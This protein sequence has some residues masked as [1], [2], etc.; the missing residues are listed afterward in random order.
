MQLDRISIIGFRS[1]AELNDL[2]IASPTLLTGHND[3]GKTTIL[4]AVRFLLNDYNLS[5]R[6]PTFASK[7]VAEADGTETPRVNETVVVGEFTLSTTESDE[8]GLPASIKIRRYTARGRS[9][10]YEVWTKVPGDERLRDLDS[11]T[12]PDLKTRVEELGLKAESSLKASLKAALEEAARSATTIHRW[13]I[14]PSAVVNALPRIARFNPN[15]NTDAEDAIRATLQTAY[16]SHSNHAEFQGSIKGLEKALEKKL[17]EDAEEIRKHIMR[18]CGDIGNV[19]ILPSVKLNTGLKATQISVTSKSGEHI[20]LGEAGAGRAR[21]VSLAVW[22]FNTGMLRDSGD[23]VLVYDEPDNHLDYAHQRDFMK[24]VQQQS[25]YPNV[26][27]LIATHSMNLIDGVDISDVVHVK[28]VDHRTV[29]DSMTDETPTGSHLGAI[30]S[31]L[32]LRNTVLLHERLFV[33]VEGDTEM[34]SLPILFR[35]ATGRHLESAGIA[36]WACRNNEGA[37]DFARFLVDHER[38]VTFL[39]DSDSKEQAR[40][41]FSDKKLQQRGLSPEKHAIYIGD[42]NE[43]EEL[44]SDEVWAKTANAKWPRV[45]GAEWTAHHFAELRGKKFS[46]ELLDMTREASEQGPSSKPEAMTTL[47]LSLQQ[48]DK[49]PD[50]LTEVFRLLEDRAT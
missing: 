23:V 25:A 45:D 2:R 36:L 6:D 47:A 34:A 3:A 44:F 10:L 17:T 18:R 5:D 8:L 16:N 26:R 12:V 13:Q 33:G 46:K 21:R 38:N 19:R 7:N 50:Q 28:H 4:D 24:L 9:A 32:G 30:A 22:E 1:I 31:S 43:L 35:H 41:V 40:H 39:V 42:P 20:H 11:L 15:G 29:A 14:A 27:M 49:L 37:M 48:G